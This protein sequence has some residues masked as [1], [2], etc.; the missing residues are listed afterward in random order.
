MMHTRYFDLRDTKGQ[1]KIIEDQISAA[2]DILRQ[3][4]LVGIPTETVYGLG[5]NALDADAVNK[6]FEPRAVRRTT[7]SSSIFRDP[8]GCPG[9]V[10]TCRRWRIRWP[11]N[12][13]PVL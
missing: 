11:G 2:A 6:I 9:T 1:Q 13:G 8:S 5:A 10:R 4:G 12:S 3:G 7:L